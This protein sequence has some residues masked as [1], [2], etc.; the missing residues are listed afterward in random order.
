MYK[1]LLFFR[2][3]LYLPYLNLVSWSF[4]KLFEECGLSKFGF[5]SRM[6]QIFCALKMCGTRALATGSLKAFLEL[7]TLGIFW[8][9]YRKSVRMYD[10]L[11]KSL[12]SVKL[13]FVGLVCSLCLERIPWVIQR[14]LL[15]IGLGKVCSKFEKVYSWQL[16]NFSSVTLYLLAW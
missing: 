4:L 2:K 14:R 12:S 7:L 3:F 5:Y 16:Q 13:Y 8:D 10:I 11:K 6:F 9:L 15:V 1:W